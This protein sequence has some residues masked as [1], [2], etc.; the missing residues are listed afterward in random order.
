MSAKACIQAYKLCLVI[1]ALRCIV[2]VWYVPIELGLK[3]GVTRRGSLVHSVSND[4]F[5]D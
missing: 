5:E 3:V 4:A 2:Y 1:W